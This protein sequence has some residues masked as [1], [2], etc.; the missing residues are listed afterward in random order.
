M[1][2]CKSK[3]TTTKQSYFVPISTQNKQA[4]KQLN[5]TLNES[6]QNVRNLRGL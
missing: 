5:H 2:L 3:K 6:N 4:N 1:H